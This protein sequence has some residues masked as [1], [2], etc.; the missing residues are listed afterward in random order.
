MS[1][2][3]TVDTALLARWA[4]SYLKN[5]AFALKWAFDDA[6]PPPDKIKPLLAQYFAGGEIE[7]TTA[8][9]LRGYLIEQLTKDYLT[10]AD[11]QNHA[12]S[13]RRP[14][15]RMV[16]GDDDFAKAVYAGDEESAGRDSQKEK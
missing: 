7:R 16:G 11:E 2:N 5:H 1:D 4:I 12:P 14:V 8:R 13:S 6:D 3:D 10:K 9:L 15:F